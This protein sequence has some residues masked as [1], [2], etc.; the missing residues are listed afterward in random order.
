MNRAIRFNKLR[1]AASHG[2]KH[3]SRL[4]IER[5]NIDL[6]ME[7]DFG[8]T[9]VSLATSKGHLELVNYIL[10]L[11]NIDVNAGRNTQVGTVLHMASSCGYT[12]IVGKIL[13]LGG[14][15]ASVTAKGL[16][17]LHVAAESG[18]VA[19]IQLLLAAG[20]DARAVSRSGTTPLYRAARSGSLEAVK[21]L[22]KE[23]G[24]INV[25]T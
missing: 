15:I 2:L 3:L 25:A 11:K 4:L 22:V 21:L 9:P 1:V 10:S 14:D 24:D 5:T 8:R 23:D 19:T 18:K 17:A 20:S 13:E 6:N 7:D 12:E 16:T